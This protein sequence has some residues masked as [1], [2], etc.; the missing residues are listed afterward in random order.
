VIVAAGTDKDLVAV[1][2]LPGGQQWQYAH[3]VLYTNV[4]CDVLVCCA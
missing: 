1:H 4:I 3:S 2:T